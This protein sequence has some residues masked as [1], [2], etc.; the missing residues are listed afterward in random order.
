LITEASVVVKPNLRHLYA[1]HAVAKLGSI[2][3]AAR[4]VHL[5]QPAVTQAVA[6]L[7]ALFGTQLFVR[8]SAGVV[9]TPAGEIAA[10]RI[11]RA[12]T[13]LQEGLSDLLRRSGRV[14][15]GA[16]RL[17]LRLTTAQLSA[18]AAF[19]EH[20]GFTRAA[21]ASGIAEPTLHRAARSLER[22]L[23][24]PLFEKTSF[25][26]RPTRDAE[27]FARHVRLVFTELA[28]AR[29]DVDA[30]S[31]GSSGKTVIGAMPL[32]RSFIVP[33]AV[34]AFMRKHPEH[35]VS[36]MEGPY[37]HLFA[38]LQSGE[39]DFLIGALRPAR[40]APG[41]TQ[42]H[43]FNDPLSIAVRAGHPLAGRKRLR[44]AD[45]VRYPWIAPRETSPL[46]AQFDELFS[47]AG[48]APPAH[49]VQC[50]SLIAARAFLLESDC[51][52]LSSA[53]QI[54]YEL[55]AGL[56]V[57]IAHPQGHVVRSIGLT[58][59]RNWQPT[60]AQTSLLQLIRERARAVE[61]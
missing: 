18:L 34:M 37:E 29:S 52:M 50:N 8:R 19:A 45:L 23:E 36:V 39:T 32:A 3:A 9:P 56:L 61:S 22:T 14:P 4:E 60:R 30:L 44:P 35:S 1:C 25:G 33:S 16:Q 57:G 26:I 27:M 42:E 41:V 31:G 59:R 55:R 24:L 15:A 49:P 40:S 6:N 43:L 5:S 10:E 48:V 47:T 12:L 51:M 58:T 17:A 54:H 7:E 21:R 53:H 2:S 28:Q 46:R 11:E 13:Q 20:G 38:S